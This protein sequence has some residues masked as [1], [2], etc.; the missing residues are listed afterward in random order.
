MITGN[1]PFPRHMPLNTLYY[2]MTLPKDCKMF[3]PSKR[4]T[5]VEL[6]QFTFNIQSPPSFKAYFENIKRKAKYSEKDATLMLYTD[7]PEGYNDKLEKVLLKHNLKLDVN[8]LSLSLEELSMDFLETRD[9][10]SKGTYTNEKSLCYKLIRQ[11]QRL[12]QQVENT[13]KLRDLFNIEYQEKVNLALKQNQLFG[14]IEFLPEQNFTELSPDHYEI[15]ELLNEK[16]PNLQYLQ[17][18]LKKELYTHDIS[19]STEILDN[20]IDSLDRIIIQCE[21]VF[22]ELNAANDPESDSLTSQILKSR[23]DYLSSL[24]K[25]IAGRTEHWMK[26]NSVD[27]FYY[28]EQVI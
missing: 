1:I 8:I 9:D 4:G 28:L 5:I 14:L 26:S 20:E 3:S 10:L 25:K 23:C 16:R 11:C 15:W 22:E 2:M 7:D 24:E 17:K 21:M 12:K 19:E 13:R 18:Y 6:L 27:L